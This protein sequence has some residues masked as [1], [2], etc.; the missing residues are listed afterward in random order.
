MEKMEKKSE[1]MVEGHKLRAGDKIHREV[2]EDKSTLT[3]WGNTE[4]VVKDGIRGYNDTWTEW[5][6]STFTPD[7]RFVAGRFFM[8]ESPRPEEPENEFG[9]VSP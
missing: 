2:R 4:V 9:P 1:E 3:F 8:V 5:G 7:D 6:R